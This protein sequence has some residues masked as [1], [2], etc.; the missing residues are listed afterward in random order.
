VL[1]NVDPLLVPRLLHRLAAMGHGDEI[2]VVDRNY[3]AYSA[4]PEVIE[5]A[6]VGTTEAVRAILTVL[7]LDTFVDRPV[8]HMEPVSGEPVLPIHREVLELASAAEG[9]GVAA[10]RLAR[11]EFYERARSAAAIVATTEDRPYGCFLLVKGVIG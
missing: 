9:R 8:L 2:A 3:P 5:L 1:K 4:G 10:Q 11:H 6:G 7:P